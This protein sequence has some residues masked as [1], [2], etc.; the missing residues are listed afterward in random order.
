MSV[1]SKYAHP[2]I[3]FTGFI[4]SPGSELEPGKVYQVLSKSRPSPSENTNSV[5][6]SEMCANKAFSASFYIMKE[7][8]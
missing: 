1:Y 5:L 7:I 2:T 4:I 8:Y 3:P 6:N